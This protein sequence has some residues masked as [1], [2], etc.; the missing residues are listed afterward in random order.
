MCRQRQRAECCRHQPRNSKHRRF[1]RPGTLRWSLPREPGPATPSL[2]TSGLQNCERIHVCCLWSFVMAALGN[3]YILDKYYYHPISQM[4][5]P[6]H[7][8]VMQLAHGHTAGRGRAQIQIQSWY[9]Q[10]Q[11][12]AGRGYVTWSLTLSGKMAEAR[13]EPRT[14][15][16]ECARFPLKRP[17]EASAQAASFLE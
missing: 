7:R 17:L 14:L 11:R 2:Q 4:R 8:E 12:P 1:K 10:P 6:R 5:K 3:Q 15:T 9:S 13:F 16:G